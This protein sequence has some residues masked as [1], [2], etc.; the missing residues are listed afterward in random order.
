MTHEK[1]NKKAKSTLII[2][3][4]FFVKFCTNIGDE[5][6]RKGEKTWGVGAL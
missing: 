4:Y 5:I 6:E 3:E 1:T 2:N